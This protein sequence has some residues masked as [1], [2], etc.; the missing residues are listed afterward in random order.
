M[1]R[2]FPRARPRSSSPAFSGDRPFTRWVF[3]VAAPLILQIW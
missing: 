1:Q 3:M 2:S